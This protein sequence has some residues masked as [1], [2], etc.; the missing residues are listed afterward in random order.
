MTR[1]WMSCRGGLAL[2]ALLLVAAAGAAFAT[3]TIPATTEYRNATQPMVTGTVLMMNQ[4]SI[5]VE[6]EQGDDVTLTLD[7]RSVVPM[8][9]TPGMMV[10]VEFHYMNDGSRHVGRVIPVRS[11]EKTTREVAYSRHGFG[12]EVE[13]RYAS[14]DRTDVDAYHASYETAEKP[15]LSVNAPS[16]IPATQAYKVATEPVIAGRVAGVNDQR[17]VI[18]T[19]HSGRVTLQM[20]SRTVIPSN[21]Q[22]GM[23]VRVGYTIKDNGAFLAQR[24]T[25]DPHYAHD[26]EHLTYVP[27]SSMSGDDEMHWQD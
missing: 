6:T 14:W 27:S 3:T 22:S 17:I 21:L 26:G 19:E 24:V 23:G 5:S 2:T 12:D 8:D 18:D 4:R 16:R 11:G 15:R 7:S 25:E 13:V 9:L 20:D 1:Q 10:R